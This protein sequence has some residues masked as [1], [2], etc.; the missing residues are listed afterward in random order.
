MPQVAV[1]RFVISAGTHTINENCGVP[2]ACTHAHVFGAGIAHGHEYMPVAPNFGEDLCYLGDQRTQV[3][4]YRDPWHQI[5]HHPE[6]Q[7]RQNTSHGPRKP[8]PRDSSAR[9]RHPGASTRAETASQAR[10]TPPARLE[11]ILHRRRRRRAGDRS[12]HHAISNPRSANWFV[13]A[14]AGARGR[15]DESRRCQPPPNRSS[16]SP[17]SAAT[18]NK[19]AARRPLPAILVI[20]PACS[21]S[22]R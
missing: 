17:A 4:E 2:W 14:R 1:L 21:V 11:P 8:H 9:R 22:Q 3:S 20:T 18:Q 19:P 15:G 12:S 10:R 16:A 5:G 7:T 13:R 6:F